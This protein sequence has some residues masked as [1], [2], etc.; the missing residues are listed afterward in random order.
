M[1]VCTDLIGDFI[2]CFHTLKPYAIAAKGPGITYSRARHP[3][4]GAAP[5]LTPPPAANRTATAPA[6]ERDIV[7]GV[8]LAGRAEGMLEDTSGGFLT[9][10]QP[11]AEVPGGHVGCML[12]AG[13][14]VCGVTGARWKRIAWP[15]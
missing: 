11:S 8:P 9:A 6:C 4:A 7:S 12:S 14:A 10:G 3:V 13:S 1:C 15:P 5:G 2:P